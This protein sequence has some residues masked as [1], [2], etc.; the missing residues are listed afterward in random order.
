M[1][2]GFRKAIGVTGG[3]GSGKSL[4]LSFLR[5]WGYP[6]LSADEVG[7]RLLGRREI[8]QKVRRAFGPGVFTRG[9]VDRKKLAGSAFAGP[10]VLKRIDRILHPAIR[11]EVGKWVKGKRRMGKGPLF[12][13]VPLLF[14][15]RFEGLFDGVLSVS[16]P[17]ATRRRRVGQE[18]F[19]ERGPHQW[20][21]ARKDRCA[22]WVVRNVSTRKRF[23]RRLGVWVAEIKQGGI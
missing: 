7:H 17:A 18:R 13:E 10:G 4:A 16:A 14:E 3:I 9:R 2:R 19:R 5:R 15:A 23:E 22:D 11:S 6:V 8:A 1:R 20:S 21:Q 12:V